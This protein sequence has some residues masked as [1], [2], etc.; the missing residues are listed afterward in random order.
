VADVL[1]DPEGDLKDIQIALDPNSNELIVYTVGPVRT[2]EGTVGAALVGTYLAHEIDA[3]QEVAVTDITLFDQQGDVIVSTL[4]PD[5]QE[6]AEVFQIF[7]PERFQQVIEQ[8]DKV[9]LLDEVEGVAEA[10]DQEVEARGQNYRL[11]YAPFILRDRVYGVYAV[12]LPTNFITDTNNQSRLW[13]S[14]IFTLGVMAVLV[15]G[16]A[17]SQRIIRPIIRLVQTSQDIAH[18][19][20]DRRTGLKGEDEIGILASTFDEMTSELQK[21]TIAL[22]EE[23]SKLNAI[24][25]SIADGVIVQDL[26]GNII[27]T[28]PAA[29]A[30][31][32]TIGDDFVHNQS[33]I[34]KDESDPE[35]GEDEPLQMLSHLTGL[36][37]RE[38]RRFEFE[39]RVLSAL[40]APVV[41][42]D[43]EQ[44]GSVVVLR[45]ITRE[46]EA[47]R[48][49]DDFITSMSHELRT[50]PTA[51]KG[52]NDLLKMMASKK[53]S[54]REL[55]FIEA[56]DQN[57]TDLLN[58]IQQMLDL[59]Q[60]D[61]GTLGIDQETKNLIQIIAAEA[62][63]WS[64]QME[65]KGLSFGV[66]L[67]DMP[68]WIEGD[69]DR[70]T[71]VIRNLLSNAYNYTLSGGRVEIRV[72]EVG[73]QVRVD[74]KDTGVG[75]SEENQ[76]FLFTRF[77]RAIHE[78]STFEVSGA[79]LGLYMSRAIIEAH[80]GKMWLEESELL[81][82]STF[83]FALPVVEQ[84]PA[85]P[86]EEFVKVVE[87]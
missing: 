76:R 44:L 53:L 16:Y 29:E 9:T 25:N 39:R 20:L 33:Q 72:K 58:I 30:I 21:K 80:G 37:F 54:E 77:F 65:K 28:N 26:E 66:H 22:R 6:A 55:G 46:V 69:E 48:L 85:D 71:Q 47:E 64:E 52:Y 38:A 34:E 73:D 70:L 27:T 57:V 42:S 51:I 61:A 18:G 78:E 63:Y 87:T 10:G 81:H 8:G 14:L 15:I 17:I 45:D 12:A 59:S 50:P 4:V 36:E 60:I 24:L 84:A 56:I 86:E 67:S 68:I 23:A 31:I 2:A 11:A 62:E 5:K 75:I 3:I 7:T 43:G 19:N 1:S 40:S 13:L 74:V 79:G 32:A 82:G 35:Q 83:S 41:T 49:K